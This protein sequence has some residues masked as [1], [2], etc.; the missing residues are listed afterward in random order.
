MMN[1]R[2]AHTSSNTRNA[3]GSFLFSLTVIPL[4]GDH[5]KQDTADSLEGV[6]KTF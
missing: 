6:V 1:S 3:R 2:P 4:N 5:S